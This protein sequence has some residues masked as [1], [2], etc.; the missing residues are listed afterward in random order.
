MPPGSG[1]FYHNRT[2]LRESAVSAI[3]VLTCVWFSQNVELV[4]MMGLAHIP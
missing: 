3:S 4:E 2:A 1:D